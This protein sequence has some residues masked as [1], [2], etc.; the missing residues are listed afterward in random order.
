MIFHLCGRRRKSLSVA[1]RAV[2][3][4][5]RGRE[6]SR[7]KA[8]PIAAAAVSAVLI[9]GTAVEAQRLSP[10]RRTAERSATAAA[11]VRVTLVLKALDNPFFVAMYQGARDAAPRLN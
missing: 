1:D 5:P 4:E 10:G 8:L 7:M 11:P 9:A 2:A 3:S 6:V